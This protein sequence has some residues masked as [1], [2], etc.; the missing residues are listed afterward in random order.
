MKAP[1]V[2][3]GFLSPTQCDSLVATCESAK[4]SQDSNHKE[5][6]QATVDLEVDRCPAVRDLIV[7]MGIAP[8]ISEAI[9][10]YCGQ[11]VT[12]FN[13][14]FVVKYN[15]KE[16]RALENH[17]DA[18]DVSFMLALSSRSSYKGGGTE[19]E[20]LK[21]EGPL[22]LEQG[23]SVVFDAG[24]FHT[25]EAASA[26]SFIIL[27]FTIKLTPSTLSLRSSPSGLPI[28]SGRRY[29]LV[30]FCYVGA[31][32]SREAGNLSISTIAPLHGNRNSFDMFEMV[33]FD[34]KSIKGSVKSL[35]KLG[36]SA[37]VRR[38]SKT[39]SPL[40]AFVLAVFEFHVRRLGVRVGGGG[41]V[42]CWSQRLDVN[43]GDHIPWHRDKDEGRLAR[44]GGLGTH[45]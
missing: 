37:F 24:S 9:R 43:K 35:A 19:F 5:Y 7:G 44:G 3:Q 41:G 25:G 34:V 16:Q 11:D 40:G 13:D 27:S 17:T 15:A 36:K 10:V 6:T 31:E 18:G 21:E 33:S 45:W 4:F 2:T 14:L 28:T 42:E 12:C 39:L 1:K 32:A 23:S 30:A 38:D 22:H 26:V 20:D 29:L 8:K